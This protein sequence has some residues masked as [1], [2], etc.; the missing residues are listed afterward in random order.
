MNNFK[1]ISQKTI[2]AVGI[3][4]SRLGIFPPNFSPLGSFGFFGQN[5]WLYAVLI[6]GF[7]YFVGGFYVGAIFTYLGFLMYPLLGKIAGNHL[8]RQIVL[9]PLASL[10][11]YLLS[12]FGSFWFFYPHSWSGLMTCYLVAVPFYNRTLMS[13]LVFGWG[14]LVVKAI[15]M[16]QLRVPKFGLLGLAKD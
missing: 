7:D 8:K 12:N 6:V 14:Y 9:L 11:F 13:D 10:S 15:R 1:R 3:F 2:T 16:N 4:I 5:I